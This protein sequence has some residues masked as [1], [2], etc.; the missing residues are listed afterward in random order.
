MEWLLE[1]QASVGNPQEIRMLR[2]P[3]ASDIIRRTPSIPDDQTL[4]EV[5]DYVDGKSNMAPAGVS[6][7][8][9]TIIRE[10]RKFVGSGLSG[11]MA[12]PLSAGNI[13]GAKDFIRYLTTD[14]AQ[15]IASQ[16]TSGIDLLPFGYTATEEELGFSRTPFVNDVNQILED[17]EFLATVSRN[18][19]VFVKYTDFRLNSLG[20]DI[21]R[22]VFSTPSGNVD[23]AEEYYNTIY[24]YNNNR[25]S[26][27]IEDYKRAIGEIV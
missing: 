27:I 6:N 18:S 4:R 3:I 1:E 24:D 20:E 13:E 26:I 25:W 17:S 15:I 11:A 7:D 16:C 5:I 2:I 22:G 12:I 23:T 19:A 21:V 9:I 8:D 10:A 14:R